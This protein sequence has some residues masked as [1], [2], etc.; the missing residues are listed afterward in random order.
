MSSS[1]AGQREGCR[2][3]VG[4][5]LR[6]RPVQLDGAR[7]G[8]AIDAL[9]LL[10]A[11]KRITADRERTRGQGCLKVSR[12]YRVRRETGRWSSSCHLGCA[13]TLTAPVLE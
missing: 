8:V 1:R 11:Q 3:A 10:E 6:R 12:L 2:S 5:A 4:A 9:Q 7:P 13:A